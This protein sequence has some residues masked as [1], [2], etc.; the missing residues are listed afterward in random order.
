MF[1]TNHSYLCPLT[2]KGQLKHFHSDKKKFLPPYWALPLFRHILQQPVP[3][4]QTPASSLNSAPD[5]LSRFLRALLFVLLPWEK[6]QTHNSSTES[7]SC[8]CI[9]DRVSSIW[10]RKKRRLGS[11]IIGWKPRK[12][13][14]MVKNGQNWPL[15]GIIWA[16]TLVRGD[17]SK[18]STY[19]NSIC[20]I[21]NNYKLIVC[22]CFLS[23]FLIFE[24]RRYHF[25]TK[26]F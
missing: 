2:T 19:S 12:W 22:R 10:R 14:K 4:I 1:G 5:Q 3:H 20:L 16:E 8:W 11:L 6:N 21:L 7:D 9:S 23:K 25:K 17:L 13:S 26:K 24:Y 18:K 15:I